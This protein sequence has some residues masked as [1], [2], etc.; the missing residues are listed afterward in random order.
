MAKQEESPRLPNNSGITDIVIRLSLVVVLAVL[1]ARVIAPFI[2]LVIWAL[3]LAITLFPAHQ[4]LARRLGG[5]HGLSATLLVLIGMTVIGLPTVMLGSSFASQVQRLYTSMQDNT[6]HIAQPA[7]GVAEWPLVGER[8]FSAWSDAATNLPLYVQEHKAMFESVARSAL[9]AASDT[10]VAL[11][12]FL[13]ALIVAGFI[14][15]W[16]QEG[17]GAMD[18]I[19]RRMAGPVKGPQLLRLQTA[20]VR[21]V[22]AGV[23][24]VAFIQ[25]LLLGIGF[26]LADVPAPGVL[27]MIVLIVGILQLPALVVSLPAIAWLW[28][29][30]DGSTT[31]TV[32]WTVYLLVAGMS[33]NV[34]KPIL[35]GRGV[36]V[37]MPVVL[38]GALGGMIWAGIIGLFVGAALLAVGY[39]IFMDWVAEAGTGG[40]RAAVTGT[41]RDLPTT[42]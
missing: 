23:V 15:A 13:A 21:S 8:L 38:L 32:I 14:M 17:G 26:M 35:L 11:L 5:R 30:G 2:G 33:D 37:P 12:L 18:R 10:A 3:V 31:M 4:G 1:C 41:D 29:N 19:F 16:G 42:G 36:A 6:L 40:N 24:G 20:T 22:A 28:A 9:G 25:A 34:L 27:A 7:P 39:Q